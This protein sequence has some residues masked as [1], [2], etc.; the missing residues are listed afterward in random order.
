MGSVLK[1]AAMTKVLL[2][3]AGNGSRTSDSRK[4]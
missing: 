1:A 2:G 3:G 4:R